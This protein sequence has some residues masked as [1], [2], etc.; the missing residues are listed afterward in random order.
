MVI[1]KSW[2]GLQWDSG[3]NYICVVSGCVIVGLVEICSVIEAGTCVCYY[4]ILKVKFHD[5]YRNLDSG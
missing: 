1:D 4:N 3:S 5:S 2:T